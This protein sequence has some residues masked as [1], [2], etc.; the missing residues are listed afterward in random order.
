MHSEECVL[1]C[2]VMNCVSS[3]DIQPCGTA[4]I[5]RLHVK[6]ALFHWVIA[7]PSSRQ[8]EPKCERHATFHEKLT[9]FVPNVLLYMMISLASMNINC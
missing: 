6:L 4:R 2:E 7:A 9:R 8:Q 1:K 5:L 3:N